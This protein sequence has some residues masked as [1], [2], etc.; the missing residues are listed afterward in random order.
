VIKRV[1]KFIALSSIVAREFGAWLGIEQ[2]T[3]VVPHPIDTDFFLPDMVG[4]R[5]ARETYN[6][7]EGP[8]AVFVGR[9]DPRK[10]V[11]ILLRAIERLH[12]NFTT[13]IAGSGIE[14]SSLMILSRELG[15]DSMVRFIGSVPRDLLPGLYSGA[16]F[17]VVPSLSE[18]SPM[19]VMEALSC[20][21]PVVATDLPVL[22]ELVTNG[23]NGFLVPP[24]PAK[25]SE[26]MRFLD[27]DQDLKRRMKR[28]ARSRV[29][30]ENSPDV[31]AGKLLRIY[32]EM[33]AS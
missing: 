20:G 5:R 17:A 33:A 21:T 13:I 3:S 29:L 32:E 24:D 2:K 27:S 26:A 6:L 7:G 10:G 12:P 4:A 9:L 25:L 8:Y 16:E 18:M 14:R 11:S 19:V 28:N 1:N 30:D 31:I 15:I 22:K 23:Q